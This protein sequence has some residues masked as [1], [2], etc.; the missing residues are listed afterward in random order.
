[1]SLLENKLAHSAWPYITPLR[2]VHNIDNRKE[3]MEQQTSVGFLSVFRR[4]L[5]AGFLF[6]LDMFF[7]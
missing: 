7:V 3:Q 1:M 5:N 6:W 2:K 4:H